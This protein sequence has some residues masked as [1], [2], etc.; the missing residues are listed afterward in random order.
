MSTE[1]AAGAPRT[2]S[3]TGTSAAPRIVLVTG[4]TGTLGRHVVAVLAEQPGV[5]ARVLSRRGRAADTPPDLEW[6]TADL[7]S[8]PLEAALEGIDAVIHLASE[9]GAGEADV[10]GTRR[11]L[12]AAGLAAV[13]HVVVISIIGC[14][15]VPLPFYASKMRIEALTRA[16]RAP[17][18]I[19][20]VAQFHSFVERLVATPASL[21]VPAP[22]I[23]DLRFQPVDE[24]E[25]AERLV[26][27]ALGPPL[28]DAP[29]IAGPEVLTLGEI[30][31]A[32]L[33]DSD[34]PATLIPVPLDVLLQ[35]PAG[36]GAGPRAG[37]RA[38][39][40]S[41][42]GTGP[43]AR[44]TPETRDA[45]AAPADAAWA[46][47]GWVPAVLEGYRSGETTARGAVTPGRVRF[48]DWLRQRRGSPPD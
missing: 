29:E 17:W 39:L 43:G 48:V 35:G 38:G 3:V 28:G 40:G 8:D 20:R 19:V 6:V 47:D 33:A 23:T 11:L 5:A 14:D 44:G 1:R 7:A 45:P 26:D 4:G 18:S 2:A 32:W 27:I 15:R 10:V 36:P 34:R 30:A 16:S 42:P 46:P 25:V 21:P 41:G 24:R 31:A 37:P 22:I 13:R 12:E 9:K